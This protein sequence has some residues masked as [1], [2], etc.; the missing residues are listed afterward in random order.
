MT[1]QTYPEPTVGALIFNPMG[2][3]LLIRS[4]KWRDQYVIPG[5]HIELG[6]TIPDALKRE[7]QEETGLE[8]SDI[9]WIGYQ[10]FIFDDAFWKKKHFIFFDFACHTR[11]T[12][13]QLND[14]A[15][16]YA[17]V[18][19]EEASRLAVEPYTQRTLHAYQE[20]YPDTSLAR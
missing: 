1:V 9:Q 2:K 4:H 6:E 7:V 11:S 15:E 17:W 5:G 13:V 19:F 12:E 14:E 3:F 10:E 16:E 8:I 20:K 18:T